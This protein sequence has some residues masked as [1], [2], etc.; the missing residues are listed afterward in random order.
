MKKYL[1][2]DHYSPA[3]KTLQRNLPE[4]ADAVIYSKDPTEIRLFLSS[5]Q[6]T[7]VFVRMELW[8]HRTFSEVLNLNWMPELVLLGSA[9]QEPAGCC[10]YGLPHFLADDCSAEDLRRVMAHMESSFMQFMDLKFVL[11]QNGGKTFKVDL[12]M[13]KSVELKEETTLLHTA[14]GVFISM[15]RIEELEELVVEIKGQ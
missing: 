8:D 9:D 4:F 3:N 6:I 2:I 15:Q 7:G 10:G 12:T 5:A 13:I 11:A 14:C 1:I